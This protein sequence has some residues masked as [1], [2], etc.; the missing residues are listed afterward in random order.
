M[1]FSIVML[2]MKIFRTLYLDYVYWW[3]TVVT[4]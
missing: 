4:T 3:Q 2:K 1:R